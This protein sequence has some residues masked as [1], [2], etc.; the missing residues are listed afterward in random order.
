VL[1]AR[2]AYTQHTQTTDKEHALP[3]TLYF[4]GW[5]ADRRYAEEI[6]RWNE[7]ENGCQSVGVVESPGGG[8]GLLYRSQVELFDNHRVTERWF[9]TP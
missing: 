2:L 3:W 1:A 6:L 9:N 7:E 4:D 8:F 5:Y